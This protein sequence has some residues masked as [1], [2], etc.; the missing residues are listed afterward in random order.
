[1]HVLGAKVVSCPVPVMRKSWSFWEAKLTMAT[2]KAASLF[3]RSILKIVAAYEE[4]VSVS[5]HMSILENT[6][7]DRINDSDTRCPVTCSSSRQP[8]YIKRQFHHT[9]IDFNPSFQLFRYDSLLGLRRYCS[10]IGFYHVQELV[11]G[12]CDHLSGSVGKGNRGLLN[13]RT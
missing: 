11:V 2:E 10:M 13:F 4:S 9:L 5:I 3:S 6:Y 8:K 7:S 12:S 1:M